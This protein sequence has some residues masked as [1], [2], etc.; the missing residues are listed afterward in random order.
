MVLEAPCCTCQSYVFVV[1][2]DGIYFCCIYWL[3]GHAAPFLQA[4]LALLSPRY[5]SIPCQAREPKADTEPGACLTKRDIF[6]SNLSLYYSTAVDIICDLLSKYFFFR[7]FLIDSLNIAF[8]HDRPLTLDLGP[9]DR[10][11]AKMRPRNHLL[12]RR[13]YHRLCNRPRDRNQRLD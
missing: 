1:G 9:T 5:A 7:Y 4:D 2:G 12:P 11:K 3:L 8:S 10:Q 6:V 13:Y